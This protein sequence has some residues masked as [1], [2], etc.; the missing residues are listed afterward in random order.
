MRSSGRRMRRAFSIGTTPDAILSRYS[1]EDCIFS[2]WWYDADRAEE[3]DAAMKSGRCLPSVPTT[4]D[5]DKV[6]SKKK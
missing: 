4:V 6:M 2:Y 3:L 5:F 1:N